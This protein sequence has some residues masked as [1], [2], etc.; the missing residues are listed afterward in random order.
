[1]KIESKDI[2]IESLLAGSIFHIPRF[3]RPY[4]WDEENINEFWNDIVSNKGNDYFIGSMVAF[5]KQK[6]QFGVVDGQQRLTTIT[7]L[8]CVLRDSFRALGCGDYAKGIHLLVERENRSN[9]REFVL[10]TESSFPYF[11]EHIQKFDG[12]PD[13]IVN[14]RQEEKNLENAHIRFKSLVSKSLDSVDN[15]PSIPVNSKTARKT[16]KLTELRDALLNLNLIFVVLDSEDDAYVIFETLNTRG[17]DLALTDLVKNHFSKHLKA[18]G[19]VDHAGLKWKSMLA[20]IHN[21]SSDIST[22]NFLYHF[23]ASR[24]EATPLKKLFPKFKKQVTKARAKDYLDNLIADAELYRSINE[25]NYGWNKNET[26]VARSLGA[27]QLFKLAQPTPA[28]LSLVRAYKHKKIKYGKL[29]EALKAIE[30]FHF[31]FTAVTSS[32]SSGGISA[33]YSSFARKLF[34]AHDSQAAANEIG[35]LVKKLKSRIPSLDEFKIAF[36]EIQYTNSNSKQKNLVRYILREFSEHHA[37][38]YSVDFEDL[39][40]E[41][42]H[43]Q[44]ESSAQWT[45]DIF[46]S[47]GNLILLEEKTNGKLKAKDFSEKKA[48]LAKLNCSLPV[49]VKRKSRW[50]PNDIARHTDEM[51]EVAYNVIWKI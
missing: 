5:K 24:H 37:Y 46:G 15:D 21:S 39:T 51:A 4:S 2:D 28:I 41:H 32:R 30:K 44:S 27:L 31:I 43:P 9:K 1:M 38:K 16:K 19:E 29:R 17:K 50:T 49:F 7:I 42:L 47:L 12:P 22:D 48:M 34:E 35:E 33:M 10:K 45:E 18:K 3:Q 40:I 11:Q 6:Q 13:A 20:T 36:G 14:I 8:L 26:E 23:W 25:P